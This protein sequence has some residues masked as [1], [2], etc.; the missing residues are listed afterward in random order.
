M[1]LSLVSFAMRRNWYNINDTNRIFYLF[2][3]NTYHEVAIEAGVYSAFATLAAAINDALTVTIGGVAE[4][5]SSTTTYSATTR[6]FTIA[7]TMAA[8]HAAT[9]VQVRCFAIKGGAL[10]AGVSVRG[11]FNDSH[12]LL[13]AKPIRSTTEVFN[14]LAAVG[15]C[16]LGGILW[17]AARGAL[18]SSRAR[19]SVSRS[20]LLTALGATL[21]ESAMQIKVHAR[22]RER[23]TRTHPPS[24]DD[25]PRAWLLSG[26][27]LTRR[28]HVAAPRAGA[29]TPSGAERG[30][31]PPPYRTLLGYCAAMAVDLGASG[32]LL[33][34]LVQ[35]ARAPFAFGGWALG[36]G[37]TLVQDFVDFEIE[38]PE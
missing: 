2:V 8:G 7:F 9:E 15:D 37:F 16:T 36:R 17:G 28:T 31:P 13:G 22:A 20:A 3:A 34:V 32:G 26:A 12:E 19:R 33:Y 23:M 1:A 5:A 27:L 24:S 38:Y 10:P 25:L 11:G 6:R 30:A 18:R 21:F 35:P 14:S 4:I 29:R